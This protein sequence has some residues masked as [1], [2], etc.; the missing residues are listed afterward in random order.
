ML[1]QS[2]VQKRFDDQGV[3]AGD[4]T[5]PQLAAFIKTETTK[6]TKVAKDSG[7]KAE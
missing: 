7:A 4:M 3:T 5:P 2:D 6:W 1:K